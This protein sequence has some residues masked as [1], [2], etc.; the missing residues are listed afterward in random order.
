MPGLLLGWP[1]PHRAREERKEKE[2][3]KR[4]TQPILTMRHLTAVSRFLSGLPAIHP[5]QGG[6]SLRTQLLAAFA[7]D[8]SKDIFSPSLFTA[9]TSEWKVLSN[10]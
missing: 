1:D 9:S 3:L 8:T 2:S 6:V 10:F 7:D 4:V 5:R